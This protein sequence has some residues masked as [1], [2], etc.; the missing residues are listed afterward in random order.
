MPITIVSA[1]LLLRTGQSA[2]IKGDAAVAMISV[3]ALAIGYLLM[4]LAPKNGGST[5]A[6]QKLLW[7]LKIISA[8]LKV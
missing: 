4:N 8:L 7:R 2:K 3:G 6:K 1:V 5:T